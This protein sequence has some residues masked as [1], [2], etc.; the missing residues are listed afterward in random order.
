MLTAKIIVIAGNVLLVLAWPIGYLLGMLA[1]RSSDAAGRGYAVLTVW[2][3]TIVVTYLLVS[4]VFF[5]TGHHY[6]AQ[7]GLWLKIFVWSPAWV[8]GVAII[9]GIVTGIGIALDWW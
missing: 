6:W 4:V 7:M 2:A 9:V 3:F 1:S 5:L 8:I